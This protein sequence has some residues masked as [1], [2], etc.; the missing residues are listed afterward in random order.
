[1][2]EFKLCA[3]MIQENRKWLVEGCGIVNIPKDKRP[4]K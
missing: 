1:M 4:K 3:T 2:P